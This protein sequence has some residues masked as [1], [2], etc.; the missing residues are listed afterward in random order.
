[1]EL[2][3]VAKWQGY[4]DDGFFYRYLYVQV[5]QCSVWACI[6]PTCRV[7][8]IT[9]LEYRIKKQVGYHN[10]KYAWM[11][12]WNSYFTSKI[13]PKDE[14]ETLTEE[15]TLIRIKR[16]MNEEKGKIEFERELRKSLLRQQFLI[17]VY[18][19]IQL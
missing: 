17:K 4:L 19:K 8:V 3:R 9:N 5:S 7:K 16:R 15:E 10:H 18:N 13:T 14:K 6:G 2:I 11:N 12:E 1:M